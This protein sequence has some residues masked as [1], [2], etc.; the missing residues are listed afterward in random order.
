[1]QIGELSERLDVPYRLVRYALERG[2]ADRWIEQYP[3]RGH[4]RDLGGGEAFALGLLLKLKQV[5][6]RTPVAERVVGLVE[7]GV[8]T[9]ARALCWDP[10]FRPFAGN[11]ETR[12]RWTAEV[13]DFKAIR[14][15][16]DANPSGGGKMTEFDW[17]MVGKRSK[18]FSDFKPCVSIKIDLTRLAAMLQ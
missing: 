16:T 17:S 18:N 7:E 1:M 14:L 15:A 6:M 3:G 11:L 8:R 12:H 9:V 10:G 13:G 4:H 5:G 2:H